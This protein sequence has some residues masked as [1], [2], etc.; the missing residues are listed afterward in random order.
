MENLLFFIDKII[1]N[2]YYLI[3][4]IDSRYEIKTKLKKEVEKMKE[5]LEKKSGITLIAVIITIIVLLILAG[6]SISMLTGENGILAQA[7]KAKRETENAE[8]LE[9]ERLQQ[10][11]NYISD[12]TTKGITASDIANS[13]DKEE[14]YG[15]IVKN[16]NCNQ[17]G[18]KSWRIFY[19]DNENIYLISENCLEY[20]YVPPSKNYEVAHM[21][22][23]QIYFGSV[24]NDYNGSEDINNGNNEVKKWFTYINTYLNEDSANLKNTAYLLDTNVWKVF[25]G[26]YAQ[27]AI[28]APTIELFAASYNQLYDDNIEYKVTSQTG[29][30]VKNKDSEYGA[31]VEIDEANVLYNANEGSTW[32]ATPANRGSNYL[33]CF[34]FGVL[35][36]CDFTYTPEVQPG[37]RPIV[38]LKSDVELQKV[39]NGI[40]MIK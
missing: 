10:Y 4:R 5:K 27:Y 40:F 15:A 11:E 12:K 21:V 29:Y 30:E 6:V 2:I 3:K 14:Y 35:R 38:C 20:Q 19:A 28:G 8:N 37:I 31:T 9:N 23:Y 16:Y 25:A 22:T 1:K 13:L 26:E 39:D 7:Q 17:E 34:G 36:T 33:F 24:R 32:I 18:V